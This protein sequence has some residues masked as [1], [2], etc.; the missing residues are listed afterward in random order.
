MKIRTNYVSNSSS[1]SFL[2]STDISNKVNCIKL[3]DELLQQLNKNYIDNNGNS[4]DFLS[5]SK[6]WWL[7]ELISDCDSD[8]SYVCDLIKSNKA[9]SYLNGNDEPYGYYD[10]ENDYVV[11]NKNFNKYFILADDLCGRSDD[12]PKVIDLR[13][14]IKKA[15]KNKDLNKKQKINLIEHLINF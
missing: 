4:F 7:T 5:V 6:D 13:E 10:N 15:I 3:S 12:I 9:I 1:S 14:K 2:I 8:Y 11:F